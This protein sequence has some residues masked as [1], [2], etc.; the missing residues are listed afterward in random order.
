METKN[1]SRLPEPSRWSSIERWTVER[2]DRDLEMARIE[3]VPMRSEYVTTQLAEALIETGVE[4]GMDHLSRWSVESAR[5]RR[6]SIKRLV[7]ELG[8][9]TDER[10]ALSENMVFWILSSAPEERRHVIHATRAAREIAR[11]LYREVARREER[12]S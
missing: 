10:V 7:T 2:L 12:R 8:L 3:V 4:V 11:D 1:S 6:M 9:R 5:I